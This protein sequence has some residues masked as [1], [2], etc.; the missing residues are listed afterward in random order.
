[1]RASFPGRALEKASLHDFDLVAQFVPIQPAAGREDHT[2]VPAG[3]Q[4]VREADFLGGVHRLEFKEMGSYG[5]G[6]TRSAQEWQRDTA[7]GRQQALGLELDGGKE[8]LQFFVV[9]AGP[10]VGPATDECQ[11]GPDEPQFLQ[12]RQI[13]AEDRLQLFRP[14]A[15]RPGGELA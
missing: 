8:R 11:L 4:L 2:I 7:F 10:G 12:P 5:Q 14:P 1:M 3:F 9:S 15:R 6:G 13:A